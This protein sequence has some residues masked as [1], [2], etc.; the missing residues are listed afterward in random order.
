MPTL[1]TLLPYARHVVRARSVRRTLPCGYDLKDGDRALMV[2]DNHYD[3]LVI[4]AFEIA[5]REVGA[6]VDTLSLDV[7]PDGE[8]DELE[9]YRRFMRNVPGFPA[10]A[11]GRLMVGGLSWLVEFAEARGY[12]IVLHGR[13]GPVPE[14]RLRW[15]GIPWNIPEKLASPSVLFPHELWDA[16]DRKSWER[17]WTRGRGARVR[18]T[19]PEGTDVSFT[20]HPRYFEPEAS[21]AR[22]G[23]GAAPFPG[24][25]FGHPVPPLLPEEDATGV[26]AGTANHDSRLFPRIE[27]SVEN[28]RV[29]R[30]EGGGRY[31]DL[32]RELLERT[33]ETRYP[34]FPGPGLFWLWE[35]AIGTNPKIRR[36]ARELRRASYRSYER[37]RAGVIHFG[38]GT[39]PGTDPERWAAE[40]SLPYG[41]VHVHNYF[42]T[43]ELTARDGE[44]IRL[45]DGG[46]LT[47]LDDPEIV[48]LASRLGEAA[49]L[50][51]EDWTPAIPGISAP[52]DYRRDYAPDP[53]RW[54]Q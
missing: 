34:H 26:V 48:A 6:S 52:G 11:K 29:T 37:L 24:H 19:D 49:E 53:A 14:T 7:G 3:P 40:R 16:I 2:V 38:F 28:G 5:I 39:A 35:V 1:D 10:S 46:R 50:L 42:A 54:A 18:V 43:Y 4:Q 41:H 13:G 9:E 51:R 45:I 15:E 32:W 23:F 8:V 44:T 36:P 25:L 22:F 31:G 47:A 12:D 33:G 17:L 21:R 30:V 20:L 27:V